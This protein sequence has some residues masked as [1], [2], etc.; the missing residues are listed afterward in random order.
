MVTTRVV[1]GATIVAGTGTLGATIA[2]FV[3]GTDVETRPVS[4]AGTRT[5]P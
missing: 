2:V 4:Q 3:E 1:A 5:V